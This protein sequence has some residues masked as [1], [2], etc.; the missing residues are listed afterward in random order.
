M[1]FLPPFLVGLLPDEIGE[2]K[3]KGIVVKVRVFRSRTKTTLKG[4]ATMTTSFA[5]TEDG[6]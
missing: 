3:V 6:F 4:R 1:P 5:P 2:V